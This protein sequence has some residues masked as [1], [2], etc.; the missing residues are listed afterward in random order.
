MHESGL[1]GFFIDGRA[2][3]NTASRQFTTAANCWNE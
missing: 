1:A 3:A 2:D